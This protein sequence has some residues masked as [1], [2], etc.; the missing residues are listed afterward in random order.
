MPGEPLELAQARADLADRRGGLVRLDPLVRA[1]LQELPDPEPA[2]VPGGPHRRQRVVRADHLVAEGDVRPWPEEERA[3]VAHPLEEHLRVACH[4]LDVLARDAVR[5]RDELVDRVAEDDL[6]ALLPGGPRDV[7]RWQPAELGLDR[8]RHRRGELG[9]RGEQDCGAGRTV[10][11][12]AEQVDGRELG[13]AR[14]VGD[15]QRLGRPCEKVDP[16]PSEELALR[17][18]DVCVPRADEH[19]HRLHGLGPERHR[20]NR[21]DAAE[22]EDLVRP[23]EVHRRNDRRVRRPADGRRTGDDARHA[24]R[25]CRDD[26]HVR[27]GDHR[28]AATGHVAP[29]AAHREVPVAEE[30]AREGLD[31]DVRERCALREGEAP[32]LLLGEADVV[33][34]LPGHGG[35]A[36]RNLLVRQPEALRRPAVERLR[37][38]T[39]GRVA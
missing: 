36:G 15:D 29:H 28:V 34:R 2:R 37:V 20:G 39:D 9:R 25:L 30:H 13:V 10:L 22:H 26:A 35:D 4:H 6:P 3:V 18:C 17:L 27:R 32:D 11:R 19:V 7:R 8:G 38:A 16:H 31:L 1:R 21:L 12:L 24:R 33:E 23:A 14:L 5:L